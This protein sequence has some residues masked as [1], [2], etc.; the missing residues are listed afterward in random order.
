M[1][2]IRYP[3]MK[4]VFEAVHRYSGKPHFVPFRKADRDIAFKSDCMI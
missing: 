2:I 3:Y 1:Q 4:K